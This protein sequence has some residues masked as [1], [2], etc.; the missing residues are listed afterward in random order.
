[1]PLGNSVTVF[2]NVATAFV[3]VF[4]AIKLAATWET[5]MVGQPNRDCES[6][7]SGVGSTREG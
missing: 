6:L 2:R 5:G 7:R 1:M 3:N 4:S